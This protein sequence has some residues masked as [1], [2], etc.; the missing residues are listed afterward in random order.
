MINGFKSYLEQVQLIATYKYVIKVWNYIF[1][2]QSFADLSLNKHCKLRGRF[3]LQKIQVSI[4]DDLDR[5]GAFFLI[6]QCTG[7]YSIMGQNFR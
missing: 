3:Y 7:R 2:F 5:V 4:V 6:S 1:Y